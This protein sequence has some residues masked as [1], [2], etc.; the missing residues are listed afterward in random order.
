MNSASTTNCATR[1]GGSDWVGAIACKAGT[2]SKVCT[3][4]TNTLR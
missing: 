2:F 1:N 4:R 3:T